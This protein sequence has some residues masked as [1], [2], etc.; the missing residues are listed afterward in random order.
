MMPNV[1]IGRLACFVNRERIE[2]VVEERFSIGRLELT[3]TNATPQ[4]VLATI[5]RHLGIDRHHAFVD[6]TGR[7]I[8][9]LHE[10]EA[11]AGL[12]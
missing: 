4:D 12:F 11:I 2:V 5:Y 3:N 8:P 9:V 10:G 7:P 1:P 6:Q